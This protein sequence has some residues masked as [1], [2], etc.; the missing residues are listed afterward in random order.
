MFLQQFQMTKGHY[1]KDMFSHTGTVLSCDHTFRTSKP[2]G[3]T[4]EDG[5]FVKQFENMFLALNKYGEVLTWR[6][7]KST[8]SLE[9][10][11]ILKELKI[12]FDKAGITLKMVVV[13]DC[14]HVPNLYERIF[15]G[16]KVKLDLFHACMRI[17]QTFPKSDS[18]HKKFSGE[19]SMI[20]CRDDDLNDERSMST[21]CPEEIEVNIE[22]LLLV[23]QEKLNGETMHQIDNLSKHVRKGCLLDIPE[24]CGTEMNERLHRHL[25]RSLLCGVSKIGP[26][27]AIAV[28]TCALY[29][30]NCKR[31]GKSIHNKRTTPVVPVETLKLDNNPTPLHTASYTQQHMKPTSAWSTSAVTEKR[32]CSVIIPSVQVPGGSTKTVEGIK[33]ETVLNHIIQRVLYLQDFFTSIKERYKNKSLDL[34]AFLWST[35]ATKG[36]LIEGESKLNVM[37]IDLTPQHSDNLARNLA[38]LNLT[39]DKVIRDGNCFFRAVA[40]QLGKYLILH[41]EQ[42]KGHYTSLGLG[43]SEKED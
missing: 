26:E 29:A 19:V 1:E 25:N 42:M 9:I 12:R 27:L 20:F 6:F 32:C 3:V 21:P 15:P 41:S 14:C 28:M 31:I 8:S 34:I 11:D 35:G 18:Q 39:V 40:R 24:G 43:K 4:R 23:W 17:V 7:T 30:W 22:R 36:D 10:E 2:I 16:V 33:T 13:D 37:G 5:K 38:G